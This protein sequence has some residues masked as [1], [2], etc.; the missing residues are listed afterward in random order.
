MKRLLPLGIALAGLL[1][2]PL[3]ANATLITQ[4]RNFAES[5]VITTTGNPASSVLRADLNFNP[6]DQTLGSLNAVTINI[7]RHSAG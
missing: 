1:A 6:F 5:S 2:A 3:S 7:T 4:T